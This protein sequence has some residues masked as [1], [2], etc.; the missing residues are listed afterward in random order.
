MLRITK[1]FH[2]E[3]A[4][5]IYGYNGACQHIHGHSYKLYVTL[6]SS[7]RGRD[8]IVAPGFLF[9]FK[10]LK[11]LVNAA[12]VKKLDHKLVLSRAYLSDKPGFV[13]PEN[14]YVWDVEP[15]A[16]NILVFSQMAIREKLPP[17]LKLNELKL[18]E[19]VNSY[20]EWINDR[21]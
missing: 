20:A 18:Y 10:D 19:T 14:L 17:G 5:A 16:E 7:E 13:L 4:H 21:V 2:F 3:M 9:D 12:V 15:T 11:E 1:I 8:Y 6:T